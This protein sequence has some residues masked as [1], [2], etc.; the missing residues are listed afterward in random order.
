MKTI[1]EL[2]IAAKC[3]KGEAYGTTKHGAFWLAVAPINIGGGGGDGIGQSAPN[4]DHFLQLR[5]YRDGVVKAMIH[6]SSWH[7]NHGHHES[8]K[9]APELL[10]CSTIEEVFV[11]LKGMEVDDRPVYAAFAKERIEKA[12]AEFG[13]PMAT[14]APDDDCDKMSC[15]Q[16]IL[17]QIGLKGSRTCRN[18]SGWTSSEIS[19]LPAGTR[20]VVAP[21]GGADIPDLMMPVADILAAG[22][23]VPEIIE[24]TQESKVPELRVRRKRKLTPEELVKARSVYVSETAADQYVHPDQVRL[25][26]V[27]IEDIQ[28]TDV[29]VVHYRHVG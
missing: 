1:K 14:P 5:H 3:R 4:V 19:M 25:C 27:A 17:S 16:Y 15:T 10:G 29:V 26:D 11:A 20:T 12:M 8:Y 23:T 24:A 21:G 22:Y 18:V 13:L 9:D 2:I 6:R 7:Q 28:M